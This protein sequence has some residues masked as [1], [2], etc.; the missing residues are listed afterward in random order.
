MKV[1]ADPGHVRE[2]ELLLILLLTAL[3]FASISDFLLAP[4]WISLVE[5]SQSTD[6][7]QHGI[8]IEPWI[9]QIPEES[10]PK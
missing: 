9:P 6:E 8:L 1:D 3:A 7:Y 5:V 10:K 4:S 2:F